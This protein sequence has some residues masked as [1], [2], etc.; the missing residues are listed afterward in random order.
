M[1]HYILRGDRVITRLE[2]AG[3]LNWEISDQE[4]FSP[5]RYRFDKLRD[6][7]ENKNAQAE[8]ELMDEILDDGFCL[9]RDG[10]RVPFEWY[11]IPC[12]D[13]GSFYFAIPNYDLN[14]EGE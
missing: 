12:H 11:G 7:N 4:G 6:A 10:K 1:S 8:K 5:H 9:E 14:E 2:K 13:R 3:P